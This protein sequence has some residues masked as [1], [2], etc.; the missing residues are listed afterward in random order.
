[1]LVT[2]GGVGK[3]S[4]MPAVT[5]ALERARLLILRRFR[6]TRDPNFIGFDKYAR[7]GAYH[8]NELEHNGDYKA[9]AEFIGQY[10]TGSHDVL[11]LGCGD[12]AYLFQL[13]SRVASGVGID[14]DYDAIRLAQ[15]QLRETDV[16]NARA[17]QMPLS[18]VSRDSL[19]QPSGY[20]VVWSM[21]VIEHLPDPVEL[22]EAAARTVKASG[23]I[24]IGTPLFIRDELVSPY[25]VKE[26]TRDEIGALV[27]SRL[28]VDSEHVLPERRV[29]GKIYDAFYIAVAR[30]PAA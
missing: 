6:Q 27:R 21:D 1:L 7:H 28:S 11:D 13:C 10:V 15:R 3:E 22:L 12:G 25:H 24:I 16:A 2:L 19:G 5:R 30:L 23:V 18:T 26:F 9:K 14:A 20:D 29:D 4:L 8:W 17:I